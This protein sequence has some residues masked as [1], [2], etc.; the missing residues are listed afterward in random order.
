[1]APMRRRSLLA[2]PLV[3]PA[4]RA[5]RADAWPVRPVRFVIPF[6]PGGPVEV[7]ARFIAEHLSPRLGQ[8]VIVEARPG[9]GGALGIQAVVQANDPH[10]LLFTTSA[11]ATLPALRREP[12]FDPLRDLVPISLVTDSPMA[13]LVRPDHPIDSL[14]TLL[15][16]ARAE[17]GRISYG[18]SGVGA[19]THLAGAL[20]CTMA[21]VEML[22]VPYRGAAQAVNALHAGDTDLLVTGMGEAMGHLRERRLR[23]LAVTGPRR[24]GVLPEVPAAAE[25][26]PG[27]AMTIWYA[28]FGPRALPPAL[29]RRLAQEIA[30]LREGTLLAARMAA[31]GV[32]LRLEGPEALASRLA[33]E[34]PRLKATVQKAGIAPE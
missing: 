11:V 18:S 34:V 10:L 8:P 27:Y 9:A 23:A 17:P 21:G 25:A 22:H 19:T 1:M 12:G 26:V 24:L 13:F 3:G 29:A 15:A 28:M 6:A 16:R 2:A 33:E 20:F 30:P 5:A 14:G 32:E 31:S 4:L 7:P